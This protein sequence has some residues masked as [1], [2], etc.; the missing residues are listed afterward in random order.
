M[1]VTR[2][3]ASAVKPN[4][5]GNK[6]ISAVVLVLFFLLALA[7]EHMYFLQQ[8]HQLDQERREVLAQA[9]TLRAAL[10]REIHTTL[11]LTMG[12]IV[13]VAVHPSL[14]E[15]EFATIARNL[16]QNTPQLR[17]IGLAK[18][19]VISHIYPLEGN[20]AAL[21]LRYLE[22]PQ[23]R[24]AVLRAI[25]SKKTVIAGPVDLVQGGQAF[26]SRIPIYTG[27]DMQ[28]YWGIASIVIDLKTFY[29]AIGLDAIGSE[30]DVA[31][32]G[33]DA[34]G[35][36]G[37]V[38]YGDAAL[39]NAPDTVTMPIKL[40][41]GQWLLAAKA[42]KSDA[43]V[44]D[45]PDI[46]RALGYLA[47]FIISM[48]LY[49]LLSAIG[50]NR[51]LA[52]HDPLTGLSNRRL[53]NEILEHSI[54]TTERRKSIF[55]LLYIDLDQ[56]KPV[57]DTYGHEAG[58]I[59]LKTVAQRLLEDS[60]DAD[61]IARIGGDEFV[62]ILHDIGSAANARMVADK[63]AGTIAEPIVISEFISVQMACSIGISLYPDDGNSADELI[64]HA[65]SVMYYAKSKKAPRRR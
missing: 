27:P 13:Y 61:H 54:N 15:N 16:M 39:F 53:F 51:F 14:S 52:L 57:N 5:P 36:Q 4:L 49:T 41:V 63:L 33:K 11:N 30:L 24:D 62:I 9:G 21:G 55:A 26:I 42:R 43:F 40:P 46:V 1:L 20:E 23:Q 17:N 22:N 18:D 6:S 3:G 64:T 34:T 44:P 45:F 10:E 65:D 37:P 35:S 48:L 47:A 32:K 50:R 58:D 59:V 56:F 25:K 28:N 31:L 8:Q 2:H 19:N 38:F 29:D 60:R 7:N 12:L